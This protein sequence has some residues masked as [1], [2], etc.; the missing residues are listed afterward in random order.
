MFSLRNPNDCDN[1]FHYLLIG[2]TILLVGYP[3]WG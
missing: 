1:R 2:L 3:Y